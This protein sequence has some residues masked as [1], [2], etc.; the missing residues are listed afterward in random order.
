MNEDLADLAQI[1][2]TRSKKRIAMQK[3]RQSTSR[4]QV[5]IFLD[6]NAFG[7]LNMGI[8]LS[9]LSRVA[10]ISKAISLYADQ[11]YRESKT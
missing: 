11:L 2:E 3:Y 8:T 7:E 6:A 1:K 9:G 4:K 10:F 5:N